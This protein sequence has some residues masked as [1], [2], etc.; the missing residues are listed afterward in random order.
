MWANALQWEACAEP[1]TGCVCQ[2]RGHGG[3]PHVAAMVYSRSPA[4]MHG[5]LLTA[6]SISSIIEKRIDSADVEG[7]ARSLIHISQAQKS[8]CSTIHGMIRMEFSCKQVNT[9]LRGN[10]LT[11]KLQTTFCSALLRSRPRAASNHS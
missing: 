8:T 4:A 1:C 11:T 3:P 9:I 6:A 5:P 2:V 10:S 7:L